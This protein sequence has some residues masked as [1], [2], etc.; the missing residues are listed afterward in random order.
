MCE[1]ASNPDERN[2]DCSASSQ[3]EGKEG[4]HALALAQASS[5]DPKPPN[6]VKW[7]KVGENWGKNEFI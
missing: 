4:R 1:V 2:G 5:L 7:E 6:N 3:H